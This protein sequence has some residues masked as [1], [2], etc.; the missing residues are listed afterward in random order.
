M[1]EREIIVYYS[2]AN[3]KDQSDNPLLWHKV[4][5]ELPDLCYKIMKVELVEH[6]KEDNITVLM[7]NKKQ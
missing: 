4:S 5:V 6:I 1:K 3:H 7:E 2:S